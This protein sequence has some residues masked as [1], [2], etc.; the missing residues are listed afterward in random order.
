MLLQSNGNKS[1]LDP[2]SLQIDRP[3]GVED[4]ALCRQCG[5]QCCQLTSGTCWPH[6]FQEPL[7][8]NIKRALT[9][10][11]YILNY[12]D[13]RFAQSHYH[14]FFNPHWVQP[15]HT[16]KLSGLINTGSGT[17]IFWSAKVGCKLP[18][19]S[20]P[21]TCRMLIPKPDECIHSSKY[22]RKEMITAWLPF[23]CFLK[24]L[25]DEYKRGALK[26]RRVTC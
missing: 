4:V 6:D 11:W 7:Y 8:E 12:W 26:L 3:V 14:Y 5:G 24:T 23:Q 18:L 9:S 22:T 13:G 1:I 2:R 19:D 25:I 21:T 16:N 10:G 20:R 17:C 15:R